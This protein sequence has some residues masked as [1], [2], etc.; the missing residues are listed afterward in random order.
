MRKFLILCLI[1]VILAQVILSSKLI[2]K[3]MD[4]IIILSSKSNRLEFEYYLPEFD[5]H[6][7]F[8]EGKH[9]QHI[10]L[11]G[12]GIL[13]EKGKPALPY[14][15]RSFI[16]PNDVENVSFV[17]TPK[18]FKDY[19]ISIAPSKGMFSREFFTDKKNIFDETYKEDTFFP[20]KLINVGIPYTFRS[21]RGI[22]VT[23]HPFV[24][25]PVRGILRVYEQ[26][27]V[28]L[29]YNR[30][31]H[32]REKQ[33]LQSNNRFFEDI[34]THHFQNYSDF[35]YT[36]VDEIG[37]MIVISHGDFLTAIHPY[38]EWKREKGIKTD[39]Y[40]IGAIGST[41]ADIK[42]FIQSEYD[43]GDG[44]TFIQFVGDY[45]HIPS[46]LIDRQYCSGQ[47]T[48]DALYSL[49]AGNDSYPEIF[50][51]RF[52]ATTVSDVQTQVIRTLSYEKELDTGEWLHKGIGLGSCW[53][54][55][56]G[57]LGMRDR[58]LVEAL[59]VM[60]IGDYHY[61]FIDQ[62]Y[63]VGDPPGCGAVPKANMVDAINAGRGII[64]VQGHGDCDSTFM[65]PPGSISDIFTIDDI[66]N[67]QNEGMLP[68]MFIGAPYI[69]NFQID[70]SY[71]EAWLRAT[72]SSTDSPIGA[73]AVYASSV[74]LDYASPQAA[75][76]EMNSLL[77]SDDFH[78]IGGLMYNGSCYAID[79]YGSQGEKTFQSYHI[80]GDCSLQ[81]RS[82]TPQSMT[83]IHA[84]DTQLGATQFFVSTGVPDALVCLSENYMIVSAGYTDISGNILLTFPPITSLNE[85]LLTV[86]A[87][88]KITY[89]SNIQIMSSVPTI[90]IVGFAIILC[91]L[92]SMI[93][94]GSKI[95]PSIE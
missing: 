62:L 76:Y 66:N 71:P 12:E 78:S 35:R 29:V 55:G 67:L 23:L 91:F 89:Q 30:T 2:A 31:E 52:S 10:T 44:L 20:N 65:I 25:N 63:E 11:Q 38:V 73:I 27:H 22:T 49:L 60:L 85:H 69:G 24:Y 75:Q 42:T 34:F 46:F 68:F 14:I 70:I 37:R 57:Y 81:V 5:I 92:S 64:N 84:P 4:D 21:F 28:T 7:V 83:V 6:P 1:F 47:G 87:Y 32:I 18:K 88:N 94:Y 26:L 40:D 15:S 61:T 3:G 90:S 33:N 48:S 45:Q 54:D 86:T 16:I 53:G 93:L 72:N 79:L 59:R 77:V 95:L 36:S 9:F 80:F 50:V 56:Y 74:D 19:L 82:D 51:G 17:I 8:L 39:L 58:D 13:H 41:T 43:L